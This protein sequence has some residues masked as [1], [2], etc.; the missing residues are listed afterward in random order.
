MGATASM[1]LFGSAM[2]CG[3]HHDHSFHF[4]ASA[5]TSAALAE[6]MRLSDGSNLLALQDSVLYKA[7]GCCPRLSA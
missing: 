5:F 4:I 3:S 1:L 7:S 6:E 2:V